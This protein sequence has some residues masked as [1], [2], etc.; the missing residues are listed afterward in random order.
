LY[1]ERA[2][3]LREVA[4]EA[5]ETTMGAEIDEPRSKMG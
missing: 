1:P 3:H 5:T 2:P 4:L